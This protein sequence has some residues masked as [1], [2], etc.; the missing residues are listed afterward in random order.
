[1]ITQVLRAKIVFFDSNPTGRILTRFS[2]D[3]ITFDLMFSV[4]FIMFIAGIFRS[5]TVVITI[6]V[7]NPYMIIPGAICLVIMIYVLRMGT[8]LMADAQRLESISREPIH[9]TFGM[10]ITGLVSCRVH[11]KIPY[12]KQNFM[13]S[14][15]K[16]ANS[17]CC[18]NSISRWI[19]LRLD[20]ICGFF[21]C[22]V[23]WFCLAMKGRVDTK[24]LIVTL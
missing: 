11:E 1:M 16:G 20:L 2:K 5:I 13:N 6:F 3:V 23:A 22:C 18:Y 7:I 24:I 15:Y 8:K 10:L 9:N 14:L 19:A 4:F 21:T 17:F 12:F